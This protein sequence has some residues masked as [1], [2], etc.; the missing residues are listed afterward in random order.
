M[1]EITLPD[2]FVG[3][4]TRWWPV[5]GA[6]WLAALP[7]TVEQVLR[8]WDLRLAGT[9]PL[10]LN[11]VVRVLRADGSTAVLKL[12][13]PASEHLAREAAALEFF[14]GR[15]AVALL[16][17]DPARGAT[18]LEE[19]RPGVPARAVLGPVGARSRPDG[20]E[21]A[22]HGAG[23][24]RAATARRDEAATAALIGVIRRLHRP[25]PPG[26]AL[27]EL[28]ARRVSFDEHLRRFPGDDPLPRELVERAGRLFGELCATA[29]GRV[30]LHGDLHHDNVLT[31]TREPWLA[32][33]PHGVVGD[34]GYEVG[35][36]LYNPDPMGDDDTVLQLAPARV[37]Q[38]AAGLDM[39]MDRVVAWGFVQAVLSGV[40]TAAA[41]GTDAGRPLRLARDLLPRLP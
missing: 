29:P 19:A 38:L 14:A 34:P 15:G 7:E 1:A 35:A 27:P 17:R 23:A 4:V 33:D 8:D 28:A 10:S 5:A 6:R 18:L 25:A 32:I 12:G 40:W 2:T 26:L 37:E 31:A 11:W 24:G 9:F 30:V 39:P 16:A 13:V 41:G 22:P 21:P 36:M 3:Q 20:P